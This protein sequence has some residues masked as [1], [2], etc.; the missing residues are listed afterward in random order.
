[1]DCFVVCSSSEF[2]ETYVGRGAAR[3]RS[4][5]RNAREE[6]SR[7]YNVRMR[8][9]QAQTRAGRRQRNAGENGGCGMVL[10]RAM[11]DMGDRMADVWEGV[12]KQQHSFS[13]SITEEVEY[14]CKSHPMAILF[15]DKIDA[16]AKRRDSNMAGFL[17][18]GG[19]GGCD[20]REQTARGHRL[21]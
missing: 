19:G 16:L 21:R 20:E 5:F 10:S 2:V 11:S 8:T 6:A 18:L 7:N 3:M 12:T 13:G 15:I 14:H 1:M 4:V 17:S 9:R